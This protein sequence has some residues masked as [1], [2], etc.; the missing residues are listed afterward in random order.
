MLK[1]RKFC[2]NLCKNFFTVRAVEHWNS[3]PGEV[4]EFPPLETFKSCL[5]TYLCNLV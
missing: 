1:Y 4:V 3:L 5:D 2:T